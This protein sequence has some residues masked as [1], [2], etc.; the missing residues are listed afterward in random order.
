MRPTRSRRTSPT[1][2]LQARIG[3]KRRFAT[4]GPGSARRRRASGS[5]VRS[6][7]PTRAGLGGNGA[8][9]WPVCSSISSSPRPSRPQICSRWRRTLRGHPDNAA[10]SLLGGLTVSCQRDDGRVTASRMALAVRRPDRRSRLRK[11]SSRRRM[12]R[13]VLPST[14]SMRDAVFNLPAL[15]LLLVHALAASERT[16]ISARRSGIMVAPAGAGGAR[17]RAGRSA[18][19]R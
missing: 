15:L 6:D 17:A 4:R 5:E 8:A 7:I 14:I 12:P 19:A 11:P 16:A 18:G 1:A 9:T 3:S 13:R 2:D 10:A